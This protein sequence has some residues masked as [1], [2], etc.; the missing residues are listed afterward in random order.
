MSSCFRVQA[1]EHGSKP[2]RTT[3]RARARMDMSLGPM[4]QSNADGRE[5]ASDQRMASPWS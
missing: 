3:S 1:L 4:D 2:R 5:K